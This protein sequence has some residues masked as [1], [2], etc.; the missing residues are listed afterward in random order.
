MVELL[1]RLGHTTAGAAMRYQHASQDRDQVIAPALSAL[2][3]SQPAQPVM[4]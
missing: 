4:A 1:A 2:V 3:E